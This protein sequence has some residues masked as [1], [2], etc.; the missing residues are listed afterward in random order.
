MTTMNIS[1]PSALRDFIEAQVEHGG[2]SSSSEYVRELIRDDRKRRELR[3]ALLDGAASPP[4]GVA[5][6]TFFDGL[7]ERVRR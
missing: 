1:L 5:D 3:A 2:Y 7:R 6:K 4:V